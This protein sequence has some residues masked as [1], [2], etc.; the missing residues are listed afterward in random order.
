MQFSIYD[1]KNK[2]I[3]PDMTDSNEIYV[4]TTATEKKYGYMREHASD[5]E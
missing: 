2:F 1:F 3:D 5:L 4:G